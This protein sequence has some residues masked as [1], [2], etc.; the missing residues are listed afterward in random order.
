[1]RNFCLGNNNNVSKD[2]S[3][4]DTMEKKSLNIPIG[5]IRLLI[6]TIGLG[7]TFVNDDFANG[8]QMPT[9]FGDV[10]IGHQFSP[11]PLL[12]RGMSGGLVPAGEV[13][14]MDNTPTGPCSGF[15]D[16]TPD[17]I[18]KLTSKF[19]Y[20][21]LQVESPEDTTIMISGVGGTWCNDDLDG[22]NPGISGE[23]LQGTYKIWVG[24]YQQGKYFPYTLKITE[25]K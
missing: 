25:V 15:V 9:M 23:W 11:D 6:L 19:D 12:V 4:I 20:L 13:N 18:L 1:M 7:L 5:S 22:K 14:R 24:S 2:E 10:Q 21:K 3:R 17:H 8:Q 16:E